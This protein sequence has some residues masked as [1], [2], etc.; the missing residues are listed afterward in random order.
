[1]PQ[2]SRRD[3]P[4]ATAQIPSPP[5]STPPKLQPVE[6]VFNNHPGS[7]VA[8]LRTLTLALAREAIFGR[9]ELTKCSLSGRKNSG[10]LLLNTEKMDY[11]KS[12]VQSR[13]P[14]KSQ[15]EFE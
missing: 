6:K 12:L 1:M 7:D 8:S 11:I 15:I 9:E 13:V 2:P 14:N 5:F 10:T 4:S 3:G